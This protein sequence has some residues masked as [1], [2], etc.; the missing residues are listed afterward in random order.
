MFDKKV[1]NLLGS[2]EETTENQF[3]KEGMKVSSET[4]SGNGAKKYSTSGNDF[5]DNFAAISYFKEPRS[6]KEVAKDMELLW[7]LDPKLCLKLAVYIRLITRKSKVVKDDGSIEELEVQ[8]GQGLKNEGIMRMLWLAINQP[9]TFKANFAYF[10]AAG[11][12]KDVFQM[13]SLDLQYHGWE[14]RKLD[15]NFFFL[16]IVAGITNPETTH[17]VRK[18]MPT[19][20]T[21]KNCKT[22]ESQADTLI[23]RWIAR[24]FFPNLEKESAY[25]AYRKMKSEGKAH[26]WQQLISKQLY[27]KINFDHIAGR[28]LAILVGSEFLKNHNLTEKYSKWIQ[29]KPVAKYTGFVFELFAPLGSGYRCQHIEDYKENTINAQFAQLVKTG[30]EGVNTNSKLLVVR[31]TSSSMTSKARG[32]N[33]S[34]YD[35][36]KS[37]ALYFSEF[38][39]GPFAN[40]FAEFADKCKLHQWKGNTPV[41]KYINDRCE[42]YGGTNFQSVI[43]LFINIKQRGIK[44]EDFPT[45][46]LLVSDGELD[47][48]G[49]GS[50]NDSTNFQTAIRRLKEAGLSEEYVKNFKLIMW[51]IPNYYYGSG[52]AVK[53]ED[54]ADAPNFFY[55]SGYDPSAVAFIMGT[56][57]MKCTPKNAEELFM[58]AMNQDLLNKLQVVTIKAKR[59]KTFHRNK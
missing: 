8:R 20:R 10:I 27:D 38:L 26:E 14:D 34:A 59:K 24:K 19:I 50:R 35:I 58:A 17:L 45:G 47:P 1:N 53:F 51:D 54:F 56:G 43:D 23:G 48:A 30:K 18:Y 2:S 3:L 29:S 37:M 49:Y 57:T 32:C 40:S 25:K 39:T 55:M 6:Y 46:L 36:G 9:K 44:E 12:W 31:D 41:D 28:A 21:N 5:V 7:S 33:V 16:V 22:V 42:A 15:W 13:L 4:V 11:S 52:N